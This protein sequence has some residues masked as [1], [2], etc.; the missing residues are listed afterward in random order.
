MEAIGNTAEPQDLTADSIPFAPLHDQ[1][2]VKWEPETERVLSIWLPETARR[3]GALGSDRFVRIGRV[4]KVGPGDK[5]PKCGGDGVRFV[6]CDPLTPEC[7]PG[8]PCGFE[9]CSR[10]GGTGLLPMNVKPG[11][12]IVYDHPSNRERRFN[13]VDYVILHEEQHVMAVIE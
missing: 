9:D 1:I 7:Q 4:I 6:Q 10:C 13:G 12:R 11:D 3:P 8:K 2:L 5:C